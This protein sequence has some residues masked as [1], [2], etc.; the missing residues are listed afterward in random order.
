MSLY[1][2]L[3]QPFAEYGF[4]RRALVACLALAL[5]CGPLGTF[6]ILRRMSLMGDAVA[7]ALLPGAAIAFLLYGMSLTALSIGGLIAGTLVALAA[8]LVTHFTRQR[9]DTS[10]AVFYLIATAAG[11]ML[12]ALKG[13]SVDLLQLLFGSIL[14]VADGPLIFI[15]SVTTLTLLL[16]ALFYRPLVVIGFDA[17]SASASGSMRLAMHALFLMLVVLNLVAAFH[18]LGTLMAVGLLMLPAAAARFWATRLP[19]L[20]LLS[21]L[22]AMLAGVGGL[23]LS[24]HADLPS[25]PAIVLLAGALYL[26]SLMTGSH[27]GLFVRLRSRRA[28]ARVGGQSSQAPVI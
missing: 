26:A 3:I 8:G 6:L 14:A 24:F 20:M 2:L 28:P 17:S 5:S 4:M 1:E 25:G 22:L 23:L 27:D 9:E 15:G 18:A 21:S 12:V 10:F 19:S 16:L 11:V 13:S 7:H